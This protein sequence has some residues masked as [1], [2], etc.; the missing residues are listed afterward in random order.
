M[1]NRG[2]WILIIIAI[3]IGSIF[4]TVGGSRIEEEMPYY[5]KMVIKETAT[6]TIG[7]STFKAEIADTP[8]ALAKGLSGRKSLPADRAM[9]FVFSQ[10]AKYPFNMINMNFPL[11]IIWIQDG[12]IAFIS[13]KV[14]PG[15]A[16]IIPE[17][18][19]NYVLEVN[20]GYADT[21]HWQVG[22]EVTINFDKDK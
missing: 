16:S 19:A 6:V 2:I 8:Q 22:Q 12:K 14:A 1:G 15:V 13:S 3:I 17:A 7:K 10:S 11:D 9:L 20:S 5:L 21:N 18:A 4:W